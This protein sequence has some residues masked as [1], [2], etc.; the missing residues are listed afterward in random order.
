VAAE[1]I[2][3][4][5][6][7]YC[8]PPPPPDGLWAAWNLD[9]VVIASLAALAWQLRGHGRQVHLGIAALAVAYVSPLC[10]LSAGLFSARTAHHLLIVF[11]AAP[12]L[13]G[14]LHGR[15]VPVLPALLAHLGI[16]WLWHLPA[17]YEVALS[18]DL[19]YWAGQIALLGSAMLLWR[20]LARADL[21]P[22][23]A[24]FVI[25]AMIAQMG[26]L[27]ALLTL[28]PVALY[29]PHFL[30]TIPFGLGVLED[31]QL[32]GLLMWIGS[33]PLTLIAAWPALVHLRKRAQRAMA[34]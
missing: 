1:N 29:P 20:A 13:A 34:V 31:Q 3:M 2:P 33:L 32:A 6:I 12:L 26:M 18:S 11:A 9:P 5:A 10:G 4:S 27:G 21:D 7:P 16:F 28:A 25:A 30:T 8:G 17:A 22:A 14:A 15:T 23:T 24:F 19:A